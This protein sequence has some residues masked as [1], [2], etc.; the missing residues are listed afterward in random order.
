VTRESKLAVIL[1]FAVVLVVAALI[2]DHFS[3]ARKAQLGMDLTAGVPRDYGAELPGL[4]SPIGPTKTLAVTESASPSG[5]QAAGLSGSGAPA[6]SSP[7]FSSSSPPIAPRNP[8]EFI[9]GGERAGSSTPSD[10]PPPHGSGG[11]P[12]APTPSGIRESSEPPERAIASSDLPFTDKKA[13][14]YQVQDRD[15]LYRIAKAQYGDAS[16]WEELAEYNRKL[17]GTKNIVRAGM[18]LVVPPQDVLIGK[19]QLRPEGAAPTSVARSNERD[20]V[21]PSGDSSRGSALR[22]MTPS[23]VRSVASADTRSP[24]ADSRG[25]TT[26]TVRRGD[27]L[28]TIAKNKLGSTRRIGDILK[29]NPQLDDEDSITEGAVLRLPRT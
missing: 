21:R 16:L 3:Q 13:K 29:L 9:M 27:L 8:P 4:S 18:T 25:Y 12:P 7:A 5:S 22:G 23:T 11:E 15:S 14:Q 6:G 2:S 26:Y 24:D 10:T 28:S 20:A 1:G 19:A 17:V